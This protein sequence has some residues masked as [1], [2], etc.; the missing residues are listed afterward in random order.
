MGNI[1]KVKFYIR[2]IEDVQNDNEDAILKLYEFNKNY[3]HIALSHKKW[4]IKGMQEEDIVQETFIPFL[5]KV[6]KIKIHKLEGRFE[7]DDVTAVLFVNVKNCFIDLIKFQNRKK[8]RIID[9]SLTRKKEFNGEIEVNI[10]ETIEDESNTMENIERKLDA[11][12]LFQQIEKETEN[13][14]SRTREDNQELKAVYDY[15]LYTDYS[16]GEIAK[17]LDMDMKRVDNIQNRFRTRMRKLY[18][19]QIGRW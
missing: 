6:K 14:K 3:V 9:E 2:D 1:N 18:P 8:R 5:K 16:V 17:R 10:L 11:L 13:M 19:E 15:L 7:N 4:F 12:F